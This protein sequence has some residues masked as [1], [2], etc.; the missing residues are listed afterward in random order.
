MKSNSKKKS[1]SYEEV[2]KARKLLGLGECATLSEIKEAFRKMA[3]K[4]HPDK[5]QENRE[6]CEEMMRKLTEAKNIIFTFLA[7]YR[8]CFTQKPAEEQDWEE[9]KKRFL[10][11][12][13]ENIP[14]SFFRF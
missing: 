11:C 14:G 3:K 6:E 2:Q 8:Y 1:L 4:Y 10:K 7:G 13:P 12:Y 5:C 9:W